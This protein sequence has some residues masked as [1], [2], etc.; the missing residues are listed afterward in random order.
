[1][2]RRATSDNERVTQ[3]T[4][5]D[6]RSGPTLADLSREECLRLL[7]TTSLGRVAVSVKALPHIFPVNYALDGVDVVFLSGRGTKLTVATRQA[8]VAF[9]IDGVDAF[10]RTGW[11][12][13]VTGVSSVVSDP[14][15]IER[16]RRLRLSP[17][18]RPEDGYF[19]RI[20]PA[21]VT[22]RRISYLTER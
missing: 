21:A 6:T 19:I 3:A 13:E 4:T 20:R 18:S 7:A 2:P 10:G 12:V 11:S 8:V 14:V 9:E 15:E 1:M 17:W 5:S 22:G 16:C